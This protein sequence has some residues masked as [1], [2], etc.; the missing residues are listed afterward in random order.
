[1]S[2][3]Y[4]AVYLNDLNTGTSPAWGVSCDLAGEFSPDCYLE[5][6]API[7]LNMKYEGVVLIQSLQFK[8]RDV[9]CDLIASS[10]AV[11]GSLL[12]PKR[13]GLTGLRTP[14]RLS[15]A[16]KIR[17]FG[18]WCPFIPPGKLYAMPFPL[19]LAVVSPAAFPVP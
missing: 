13:H 3:I 18:K 19:V 6:D 15:P 12:H 10:D 7:V 11:D 16:G 9:T 4:C 5:K 1:M 2:N 14:F 8:E 17:V